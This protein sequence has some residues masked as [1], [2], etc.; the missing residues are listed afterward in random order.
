MFLEYLLE[1]FFFLYGAPAHVGPRP[2]L[3]RFPNLTLIDIWQDSLD[4]WSARRKALL[5]QDNTNR[6]NAGKH[7]CL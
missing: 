4:E 2:P 1:F 5:T 7:P 6:I 3:I